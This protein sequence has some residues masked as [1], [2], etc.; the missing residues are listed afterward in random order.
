MSEVIIKA[1]DF[2]QYKTLR[3][4]I[5]KTNK[6][7]PKAE[8]VAALRRILEEDP[9]LWRAAGDMARRAVEHVCGKY[10]DGS[11][12]L[13]ESVLRGMEVLRAELGYTNSPPLEKLLIEQILVCYL[14]LYLLE[15]NT[16]GKLHDS[17]S[18]EAGLYWDRRLTGAQRRYTRACESLARVRKLAATLKGARG[19]STPAVSSAIRAV[20]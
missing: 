20:G 4:L 7:R 19:E 1:S 17:H 14:N 9:K 3:D 2:E 12:F 6:E 13:R 16:A 8:D 10:F 5:S 11:A 18:T 15:M